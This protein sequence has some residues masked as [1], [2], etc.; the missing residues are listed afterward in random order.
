MDILFSE[1]EI[2]KLYK[3]QFRMP[4]ESIKEYNPSL[5]NSSESWGR[6][7]GKELKH[8]GRLGGKRA[9]Q[10][11]WEVQSSSAEPEIRKA[12]LWEMIM[13]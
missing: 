8:V 1:E 5:G 12:R 6:G 4:W 9:W 2:N 13:A 10:E 3:E 7:H 11:V